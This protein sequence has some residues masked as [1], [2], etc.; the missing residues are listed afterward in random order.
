[1]VV[2]LDRHE[3][4]AN[5]EAGRWDYVLSPGG[6]LWRCDGAAYPWRARVAGR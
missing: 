5:P 3:I 1:M 2:T 4:R 6:G